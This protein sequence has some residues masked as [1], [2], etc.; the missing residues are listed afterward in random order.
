MSDLYPAIV[1]WEDAC[2][3]VGKQSICTQGAYVQLSRA[4]AGYGDLDEARARFRLESAA[5]VCAADA[6]TQAA[7]RIDVAIDAVEK[8]PM[9]TVL[10]ELP[11]GLGDYQHSYGER[12][13][14]ATEDL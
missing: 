5:F 14:L 10:G 7:G 13:V 3:N 6:L 4:V 12:G 1:A 11:P 9:L 2:S 8:S